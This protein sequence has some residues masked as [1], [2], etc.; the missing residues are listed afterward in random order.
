MIDHGLEFHQVVVRYGNTIALDGASLIA[1]RGSV[2]GLVG[3]NGA[4]KTTSLKLAAGLV[5]PDAGAVLVAGLNPARQPTAVRRRLTFLPDRPVLPTHLSAREMLHLRGGLYAVGKAELKDRI[6]SISDELQLAEFL[7][8]WCG[9]LS[10]GQ[11][12]RLALAAVL[13]PCPEVLL[14]DEPM[15]ALDLESQIRVRKVLQDRAC[16]GMAVLLTT[17]TISHVAALA[18]EIVHLNTGRVVGTRAGTRD[19]EELEEWLLE[20]ST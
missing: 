17:H 4:G 5:R 1:A 2:T 14:V 8:K 11:A 3:P 15:T 13:L 18:D 20:S 6:D 7:D 9:A 10:H 16:D 12:Q 19:A